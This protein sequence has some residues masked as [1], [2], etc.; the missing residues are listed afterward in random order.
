MTDRD[1]FKLAVLIYGASM[2]YSVFLWRKGFR[3]DNRVNYFVLLGAF[4]FH[5]VAMVKRGFSLDRCPVTNLYE[6]T[7]FIG[8]TM[9]AAYLA[10]GVWSRLRFLGAFLSPIIFSIGVFALMPALD[11]HHGPNPEFFIPGWQ[12]SLHAALFAL[13]YGAF[14][15][16]S[17][18]GLMYL[19][20]EHD[21]KL[22]KVRAIFSLMPPIQ[23][24]EVVTGRLLAV[25]FALLT[26]ALGVSMLYLKRSAGVYLA[27][28]PKILWAFFVW[29]LYLGLLL[30]R[31]RFA[32]GGRRFAWGAVGGFA[33]VLL[34]FWGT[35]LLSPIHNP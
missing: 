7:T 21:L 26:A 2:V 35:N 31:W 5:T 11:K 33:F 32:Q 22:H 4:L 8:W 19:T 9:V 34:T 25:G 15:L 17:G 30:M 18:A 24:L 29:F 27:D 23:R 14:G 10:L 1:Y 20:Q 6:A 3:E 28:D 13:A 16:S 12:N